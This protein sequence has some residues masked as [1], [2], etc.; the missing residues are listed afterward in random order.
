MK[1]WTDKLHTPASPVLKRMARDF[2][3]LKNGEL[4]L[5]PSVRMVDDAI[6]AIPR[7]KALSILALRQRLAKAVGADV[8]C[9]VYMGYHLRTVAEAAL[10]AKA[11]GI[12]M[13][14]LTPIWRVLQEG[15]P[16]LRKLKPQD[17]A[18]LLAQ[19]RREGLTPA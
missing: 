9:P 15:A 1:T 16:T 10:E 18:W 2:G 12:P 4:V 13:G 6:R 8:T 17:T 7:G 3:S 11:N 14:R 5:L 19:R